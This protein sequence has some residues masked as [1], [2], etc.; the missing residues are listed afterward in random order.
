MNVQRQESDKP[1]WKHSNIA[2]AL[3]GLLLIGACVCI[4]CDLVN[5]TKS[6]FDWY[7]LGGLVF[8]VLGIILVG[9]VILQ[10]TV[11][12]ERSY[13]LCPSM[14]PNMG[15]YTAKI[16]NVDT[17]NFAHP[18]W[19]PTALAETGILVLLLGV[20]TIQIADMVN[21]AN[22]GKTFDGYSLGSVLCVCLALGCTVWLIGQTF[23]I[24][25][26]CRALCPQIEMD[27]RIGGVAYIKQEQQAQAQAL[28][29]QAQQA[30]ALQAQALQAQALQAQAL[31]P[32][33]QAQ[34]LHAQPT[35]VQAQA[36]QAQPTQVQAQ[37]LQAQALQA[38]AQQAQVQAQQAQVQAQ[39]A[40]ALQA[41]AQQAQALQAQAQQ[42]QASK[43]QTQAQQQT[44]ID[45]LNHGMQTNTDH[46]EVHLLQGGK[47][48]K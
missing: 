15:M 32:Q 46:T 40:Q 36:L 4:I 13:A 22:N 19:V 17:A 23:T 14:R 7:D 12:R 33:V 20:A 6:G 26:Q 9:V 37:A 27:V 25:K 11:V 5:K 30:Q 34:A 1:S 44:E 35:Q 39:Q 3:L 8:V 43:A 16:D 41:Q 42:A 10:S 47:K 45:G 2:L 24:R 38:Q 28:Q 31:Q 21:D 18:T 29:A 48:R